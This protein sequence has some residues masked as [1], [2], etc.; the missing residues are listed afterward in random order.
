M[1]KYSINS[2]IGGMGG[3][4]DRQ[5]WLSLTNHQ[6]RVSI[7]SKNSSFLPY[8]SSFTYSLRR[9]TPQC[10]TSSQ[11]CPSSL[12]GNTFP[13]FLPEHN[14]SHFFTSISLFL[15]LLFHSNHFSLHCP[16]I[17]CI[18]LLFVALSYH[19]S[20]PL[21]VH[22]SILPSFVPSAQSIFFLA[23]FW[24][25]S[26][27]MCPPTKKIFMVETHTKVILK[28]MDCE[29]NMNTNSYTSWNNIIDKVQH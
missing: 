13:S 1:L 8:S 19:Y 29:I 24:K 26:P 28:V 4:W 5:R 17:P 2:K 11:R 12:C 16:T 23:Q 27:S 10:I 14:P 22:F 18:I 7:S 21:I 25:A 20:C 6:R 3:K 15:S 9:P